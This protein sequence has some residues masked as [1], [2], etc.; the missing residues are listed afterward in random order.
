MGAGQV[1]TYSGDGLITSITESDSTGPLA[2]VSFDY[3][4][5]NRLI[6]E[7]RTGLHPYH[8][9]Y[10]Y[11]Q[12]GNRL[13]KTDHAAYLFTIYHYDVE[14]PQ[15][16]GSLNNRLMY[17]EVFEM[18]GLPMP[19]VERVDYQYDANVTA[20]QNGSPTFIVRKRDD[21]DFYR[22]TT[23]QYQK[24]GTLFFVIEQEWP[25]D[26]QYCEFR[27]V[28]S[29]TEYRGIGRGRYATRQ[30]DPEYPHDVLPGTSKWSDYDGDSIYGDY[31]VNETTGNITN[32][33]AY[34][35]GLAQADTQ[36]GD[37]QYFHGD[38]IGTLRVITDDVGNVTG[39]KIYT[40]FGEEVYESGTVGTR[41]QYAGAWG[42]ES[43]GSHLMH[44]GYR[45]YDPSTGRFLQRDPLG[46][47]GG[48]NTYIYVQNAP[49]ASTDSLGLFDDAAWESAFRR[50]D[51]LREEERARIN[52]FQG[53]VG[54]TAMCALHISALPWH[55]IRYVLTWI[56]SGLVAPCR[57]GC[58]QCGNG[59]GQG[60][61]TPNPP[62]QPNIQ[63]PQPARPTPKIPLRKAA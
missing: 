5:R 24:D 47:I 18:S 2:T 21:Q 23:L 8:L 3:D 48:P 39:D 38:Q 54:I 26:D 22:G 6:D 30:R 46:I 35:P 16:Y 42:Y 45:H 55:G 19:R 52:R 29:I 7:E 27:E 41:Y 12:L 36:T 44:V 56:G 57:G 11:D 60:P 50:R 43:F 28:L 33:A 40:A 1:Y 14:D 20:G 32:T 58:G 53:T 63:F 15:T 31:E 17:Y 62:Q 13:T 59:N 25:D 10:T 4:N 49:I 37:I 61:Y 51:Q 34:L 9:S